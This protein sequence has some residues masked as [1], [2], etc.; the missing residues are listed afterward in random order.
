VLSDSLF[1]MPHAKTWLNKSRHYNIAPTELHTMIVDSGSFIVW[2]PWMIP[3]WTKTCKATTKTCK[4]T[5]KTK[6]YHY[7]QRNRKSPWTWSITQ[8]IFEH[9]LNAIFIYRYIPTSRTFLKVSHICRR[10]V[11]THHSISVVLLPAW[12]RCTRIE[13]SINQ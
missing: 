11:H 1:I 2:C 6:I 3:K 4:S 5:T 7:A 10:V 12:W 9:Y 8:R 13:E